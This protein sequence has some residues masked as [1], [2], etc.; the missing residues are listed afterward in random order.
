M[1]GIEGCRG[2]SRASLRLPTPTPASAIRRLLV[3]NRGEIAVRIARA[4]RE[5]GI[6][7]VLAYSELDDV[8]YV[9]RSFD[10]AVSLG[11]GD[12]RAT[13]LN[14][15]RIIDVARGCG[16]DAL[17][18]GYGFLSERAE[19]AA[20]CDDAGIIFVGPKASSIAAMG[21]K[22]ASRHLMQRLG[23]PVVPGYDGDD[24]NVNTLTAEAA[25][26]RLSG[27]RQSQRGRRRQGDEDR[28]FRR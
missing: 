8:R 23:V 15:G 24:Q 21:S 12:A 27:D 28:P 19:L 2:W 14:I 9:R 3:P 16:A 25:A 18:P 20:A 13:Y 6:E 4:C 26:D 11:A 17:H 5:A 10:D 1:G 7:S 22:A